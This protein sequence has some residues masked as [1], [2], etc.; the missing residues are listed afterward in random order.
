MPKD[1]Y[2]NCK[3]RK[4][5]YKYKHMIYVLTGPAYFFRFPSNSL[6][7]EHTDQTDATNLK[8]LGEVCVSVA[9]HGMDA[10][11]SV[12]GLA[13]GPSLGFG[14]QHWQQNT[15]GSRQ[16]NAVTDCAG[17]RHLLCPWLQ[18]VR[19]VTGFDA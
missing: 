18:T 1:R 19:D 9:E 14:L 15:R 6:V 17:D 8:D 4:L 2:R 13:R 5:P 11:D 16:E 10:V 3:S 12:L 7:C